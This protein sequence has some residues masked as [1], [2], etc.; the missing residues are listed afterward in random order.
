MTPEHPHTRS[1]ETAE[2]YFETSLSTGLTPEEAQARLQRLGL[3]ELRETPPTPLWRMLLDQ[4]SNFIVLI[5][6]VACVI[7]ILLGEY[8]EGAAILAIVILNAILGLVQ[9]SKAESALRALKKLAAPEA[10]VLRDGHLLAVP[11][12]DL[13]PGDVVVLET[14][15]YVPADVRLVKTVNLRIDEA[16]LTGESVPVEKRADRVHDA[17]T[18]LGDRRNMAYMSTVVTYGR[19]RGLVVATGMETQIG[20]IAEMIQSYEE[21]PTPLQVKLDQVGKW[22]GVAMLAI[23]GVVFVLGLLRSQPI[24]EMF[25]I[26]ISLAIAAVPEGLPAVVTIALALGMQEMIRRNALIRKLPAVETLG[27][28]TAICSDKT[29]TLTQNEMTAVRFYAGGQII[30]ATGQGYQPVGQFYH[31]GQPMGSASN[32]SL[33]KLL[34]ASMLCNDAFL[35]PDEATRTW[36]MVGD[37]TEGARHRG[38]GQGWSVESRDRECLPTRSRDPLRF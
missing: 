10:H 18:P 30:S 15:N 31:K 36:R 5:L 23:C 33:Q 9:E 11:S 24:L 19:G 12:R 13:V 32:G 34:A 20:H 3:N 35:E 25:F 1:I 17:D 2:E 8:V 14:G 29:G 22:L 26:A 7:S 28:A 16:S 37:P 4:F 27:S 21:E 38:G 6:I